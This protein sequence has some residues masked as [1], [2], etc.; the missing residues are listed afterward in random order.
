MRSCRTDARFVSSCLST[1]DMK[2]GLKRCMA[3]CLTTA[4]MLLPLALSAQPVP[5]YELKAAFVY[6]FALFTEWPADQVF[7]GGAMNICINPL[8]PLRQSLGSLR[9]KLIK[10]KRIVVRQVGT[11]NDLRTCQV[12]F[13]DSGDREHWSDIRKTLADSSVLTITDDEE[14]AHD[15]SIIALS[16]E[17]NRMVF[18]INLRAARQARLV[19][20]SKLLRLARTVQ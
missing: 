7:E 1:S 20:S 6:N 18:D 11:P 8:S 15:G 14:I 10:G 13:L 2:R 5:E 12:L 16:F 4:L 19:L 3:G 17:R 9:E